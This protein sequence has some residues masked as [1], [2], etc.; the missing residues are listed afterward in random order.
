MKLGIE[1]SNIIL[2]IK[3]ELFPKDSLPY[4]LDKLLYSYIKEGSITPSKKVLFIDS[5]FEILTFSV[6]N[7][8]KKKIKKTSV[9]KNMTMEELLSNVISEYFSI[10]GE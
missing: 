9:E 6:P 2:Q 10:K 1:E 7:S 8:L 5:D 4:N 3:P